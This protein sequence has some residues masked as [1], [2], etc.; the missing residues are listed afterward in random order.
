MTEPLKTTEGLKPGD[1]VQ[2][3]LELTKQGQPFWFTRFAAVVSVESAKRLT[4]LTL[5]LHPDPKFEPRRLRLGRA[6]VVVTFLP[7][8]QWPQGVI[9]TRMKHIHTGLLKID[10]G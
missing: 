6:D 1:V 5:V 10:G 9:A 7:E 4:V 3:A 8:E 2:Y